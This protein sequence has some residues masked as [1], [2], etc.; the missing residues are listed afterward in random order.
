MLGWGAVGGAVGGMVEEE[1]VVGALPGRRRDMLVV[2][3]CDAA[4]PPVVGELVETDVV[5]RDVGVGEGGGTGSGRWGC[6]CE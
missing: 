6:V 5:V 3:P 1:V 4:A 2:L